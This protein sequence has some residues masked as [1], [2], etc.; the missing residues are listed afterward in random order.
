MR[1]PRPSRTCRSRQL[2]EALIF[3]PINHLAKGTCQ[4]KTWSHFL[5]QC[6]V[7]ACDSQNANRSLAAAVKRSVFA[8]A[9]AAN[10]ALGAKV[11]FSWPRLSSALGMLRDYQRRVFHT[12]TFRWEFSQASTLIFPTCTPHSQ[13]KELL[14]FNSF[15][16]IVANL[17]LLSIT[18]RGVGRLVSLVTHSNVGSIGLDR[19]LSHLGM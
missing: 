11:R 19:L 3:P 12:M 18:L 1:S 6:K 17:H 7:S 5:S 9:C 13:L 8:F 16:T 2:Y 10:S 14:M 15:F 4:S